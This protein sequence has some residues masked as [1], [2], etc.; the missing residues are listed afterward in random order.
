MLDAHWNVL[1]ANPACAHLYGGDLVGANIVRRMLAD[2]AA[3]RAIVNWP[4]VAWAGLDRLRRQRDRAPFDEQLS[5]LV[6]L[7]ETALADLPRP[8]VSTAD[9]VVCPWFRV[10]QRVVKTAWPEPVG[11]SHG[12]QADA[13]P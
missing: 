11:Q 8:D 5:A 13:E 3:Q 9:L 4:E 6:R 1:S 10:G 2:P 7:A 12:Q